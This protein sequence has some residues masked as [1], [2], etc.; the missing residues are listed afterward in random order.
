MY[1][2]LRWP[3]L[4]F[5]VLAT[6]GCKQR[7]TQTLLCGDSISFE[8]SCWGWLV[9]ENFWGVAETFWHWDPR[10]FYYTCADFVDHASLEAPTFANPAWLAQGCRV[11]SGT[12][13]VQA[14]C[15]KAQVKLVRIPHTNWELHGVP[16]SMQWHGIWLEEL[17]LLLLY[18]TCNLKILGK[19][20]QF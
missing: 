8:L 20:R 7:N 12:A 11:N 17:L 15:P 10:A 16:H 2:L 19:N 1:S 5:P 13:P 4:D 9:Q 3:C 14:S 18:C 6:V